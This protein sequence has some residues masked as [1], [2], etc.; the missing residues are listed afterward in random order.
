LCIKDVCKEGVCSNVDNCRKGGGGV[1][2]L[3]D[4]YKQAFIVIIFCVKQLL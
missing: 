4:I 3:A 1:K 2:D